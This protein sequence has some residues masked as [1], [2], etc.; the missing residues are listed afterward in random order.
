MLPS[1][2]KE[3]KFRFAG[4]IGKA[5]M[6][7]PFLLTMDSDSVQRNMDRM[8]Q[9][10]NRFAY[11]FVV[12]ASLLRKCIRDGMSVLKTASFFGVSE[13]TIATRVNML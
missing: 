5:L 11:A 2:T 9:K 6:F 3:I 12:P 4:E 10:I 8:D 1:P 13:E 7:R